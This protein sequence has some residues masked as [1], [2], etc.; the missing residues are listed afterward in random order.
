MGPDHMN[1]RCTATA[2]ST[3]DRCR[4]APVPGARVCRMHRAGRPDAIAWLDWRL[5]GGTTRT[6]DAP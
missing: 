2:K 4:R 5:S 6:E 1:D 3:G